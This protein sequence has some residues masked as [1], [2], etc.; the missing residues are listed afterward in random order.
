MNKNSVGT[1]LF[2]IFVVIVISFSVFLLFE[3]VYN[4]LKILKYQ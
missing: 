2:I 3:I 1:L 4:L